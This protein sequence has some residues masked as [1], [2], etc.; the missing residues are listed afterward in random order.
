MLLIH[1]Q[2]T[3][4]AKFVLVLFF[5][6]ENH[7]MKPRWGNGSIAPLILLPRH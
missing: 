2:F 6:T 4:K 1:I 3:S 5:L 7:P